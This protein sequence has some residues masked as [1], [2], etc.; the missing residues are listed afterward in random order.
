MYKS[1]I[2]HLIIYFCFVLIFSCNSAT[3]NK[4]T[5]T[6]PEPPGIVL[7][8]EQLGQYLPL[9]KDKKVGLLVNHTSV[10]GQTHL[11]D[12]L[13]LLN[14]DVAKIFAPEHGFRG[15]ADAGEHIDNSIDSKTGVPVISVYGDHRKPTPEDLDNVDVVIFDSQDVGA[16][17]F[18]YFSAMQYMME[19]CAENG[20]EMIIFDRPNPNGHYIDGPILE[21]ENKSYVGMNPVPIVFGLTAGEYAKMMVGEKWINQAEAL[22]LTVIEMTGWDHNTPYSLTVKPSPNL[23]T[24]Q[25]IALYPSICLFEGTAVSV[26]RGTL[27][28]FQIIGIPDSTMGDYSFTPESIDGMS[29]NPKY[30]GETCYGYDLS[31]VKVKNQLDLSYLIEFY[32]KSKNKDKFFNKYFVKLAGTDQ[33]QKQIEAGI[34]EDEIRQSW[35]EGLIAYK[36]KRKKYL[37]YDDFE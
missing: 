20:V 26:G 32:N 36:A 30:L 35:A 23:P 15:N 22:K 25:S 31:N 28:P 6:E 9:L 29:K 2:Q 13:I 19:S 10:I 3:Q 18:T 21:M 37:L 5:T 17:F 8:T 4:E 27:T 1:N 33:L 12:T 24:D 7:G 11:L 16:R 34:S 14:V